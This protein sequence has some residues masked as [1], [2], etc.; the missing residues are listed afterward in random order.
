MNPPVTLIHPDGTPLKRAGGVRINPPYNPPYSGA[1]G[2]SQELGGWQPDITSPDSAYLPNRDA[3][4]ARTRDL[5]RNDGWAS[6]AV[7][8]HLDNVIGTGFWLSARPDYAALGLSH[9]WAMEWSEGVEAS[10]RTY[11]EDPDFFIDAT[12]NNDFH[13]ICRTAYRHY[14]VDGDAI[15]LS[16]WK[17]G[18]PGN[19]EATTIKLMHPDRLSNPYRA[20]DDEFLRGGV[21]LDED[22]AAIAYHFSKAHPADFVFN[23][24]KVYEWE[25]VPRETQWGRRRVIHAFDQVETGQTRGISR[26][27]PVVERFKMVNKYDRIELQAALV[28][29][30]LSAYIESPMDHELLMDAMDE[31]TLSKY[32]EERSTFHNERK[33]NLGGMRLQTLYPGEKINLQTSARPNSAFAEFERACLR[34][35]AAA[36]GLSYEQLTQ[37]WSQV[38]YSSARAAMIE[39][40]KTLSSDRALFAT[41]FATPI[42]QLW[43]EEKI[44][45]GAIKTPAGAPNF[46]EAPAAYCNVKWIGMGRGYVDPEKEAKAENMRLNNCTSTLEDECAAQ[47]KDYRDVIRQRAY[48]QQLFDKNKLSLPDWASAQPTVY[49]APAGEDA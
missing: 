45:S 43:L 8:R 47:G 48:E 33:L 18:K 46:Y 5:I 26:F 41:K 38:N 24:S 13:G 23:T 1:D 2:Q 25:R 22:G 30:L 35:I 40:W 20:M 39:V 4:V 12:R 15:A 19:R 7:T 34:N 11:A 9:D 14:L 44:N 6:S 36:L 32:Q 49:T 28:N 27:A 3:L 37:D 29:A 17:E 31:G 16:L 42:Y 10:W 21:E